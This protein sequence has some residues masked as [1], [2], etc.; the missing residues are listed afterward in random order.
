M[1]TINNHLEIRNNYIHDMA[2]A[3]DNRGIF[4]DDGAMN[5]MI[6]GN[7]IV[8]TATGSAISSRRVKSVESTV[9]YVNVGNIINGNVFEGAIR[10]IGNEDCDN[11]CE[12]G[13]NYILVK[14]GEEPPR[15]NLEN[16]LITGEDHFL[17]YAGIENGKVGLDGNSYKQM[18]KSPVWKQMKGKCEKKSKNTRV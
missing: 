14:L 10:F 9:G 18:R 3:G 1:N 17:K 7:V 12:Y 16:V 5:V 13:G 11:G 6:I 2:G 8:N 4:L 15:N